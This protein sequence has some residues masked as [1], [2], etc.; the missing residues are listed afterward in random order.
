MN[1]K[2]KY[3]DLAW[4]EKIISQILI[5]QSYL[6]RKIA[7]FRR[8]SLT[9]LQVRKT[10]PGPLL[11]TTRVIFTSSCLQTLPVAI[12]RRDTFLPLRSQS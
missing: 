3:L 11:T 8:A 1:S 6:M 12:V 7:P 2:K 10:I 5:V 9:R 4:A